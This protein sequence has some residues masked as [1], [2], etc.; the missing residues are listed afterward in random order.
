MHIG[1]IVTDNYS[2]RNQRQQNLLEYKN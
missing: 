2:H 1:N